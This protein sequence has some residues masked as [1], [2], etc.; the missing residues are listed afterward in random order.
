MEFVTQSERDQIEAKLAALV[1]NRP[2]I[3]QRIAEARALGDLKENGD[4]HAAREQQGMEEA[5]IRRLQD[6]LKNVS[7]I[8]EKLAKAVEGVVMLGSTVKLKDVE[9][10]DEDLYRLVGEASGQDTGDI[11]EVTLNSPL[12]EALFKAA[13]GSTVR[14]TTPRGVKQFA[15][16][17]IV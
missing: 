13:V 1:A 14:V 11:F 15:I 8:D 4:Y 9:R 6:R 10:G 5:E 12:G 2:V 3:S 7:V 16:I 17:E